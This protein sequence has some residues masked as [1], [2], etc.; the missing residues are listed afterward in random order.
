MGQFLCS[1]L[2]PIADMK[3]AMARL[4][5]DLN[6]CLDLDVNAV[7]WCVDEDGHPWVIDA[8]NEVPEINREA[9]PEAYYDWMVRRFVECIEDKLDSN[10]RNKTVFR[11]QAELGDSVFCI[12]PP[13]LRE[14]AQPPVPPSS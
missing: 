11:S 14:G 5:V 12:H 7:E 8:F 2:K 9:L 13:Y 1:D 6:V 10:Q 4:T 3:D